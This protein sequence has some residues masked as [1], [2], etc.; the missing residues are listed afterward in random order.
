[1]SADG[2]CTKRRRNIAENYNR[3]GRVH[4]RYRQT[5][6]RQHEFTFAKKC[7]SG[8][9]CP[10][11]QQRGNGPVIVSTGDAS[12]HNTFM[13]ESEVPCPGEPTPMTLSVDRPK[14]KGSNV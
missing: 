11:V 9:R 7:K 6:D 13:D 4:E 3:L 14:L 10:T 5:D 1:M 8:P 2:E 12:K